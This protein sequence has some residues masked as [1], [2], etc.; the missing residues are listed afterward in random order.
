MKGRGM[1]RGE[2]GE[3]VKGRGGVER[4][5]EFFALSLVTHIF[6]LTQLE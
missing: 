5:L 1:V 4:G 3:G 2:R 6:T